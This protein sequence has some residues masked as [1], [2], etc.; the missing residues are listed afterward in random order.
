MGHPQ[1]LENTLA[2]SPSFYPG[3]NI[4]PVWEGITVTRR[5][6]WYVLFVTVDDGNNFHDGFL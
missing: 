6:G 4:Y 3:V 5:D 1:N 2:P